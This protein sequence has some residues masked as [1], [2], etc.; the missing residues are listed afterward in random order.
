MLELQQIEIKEKGTALFYR[1]SIDKKYRKFFNTDQSFYVKYSDNIEGVPPSI[2]NIPFLANVMPIAWFV[3]FDVV[4]DE[5]DEVFYQALQNLKEEFLK[6]Y[7]TSFKGELKVKKLVKNTIDGNESALLFSGGLDSF[8]SFIRNKDKNPFLVSIH[9]ADVEIEDEVRWNDFI[10]FNKEEV[11]L[12]EKRHYYIESNLRTFY[13]YHVELLVNIGWWG[14][15]QHGMALIGVLAPLTYKKKVTSILIASSNTEEVDFGW[16]STPGIDEKMKWA[17]SS[18]IHDGYH[19]RRTDK[20]DNVIDYVKNGGEE[21]KLRVCY[22]ELRD[23]YNCSKCAKCQRTMLGIILA[24]D[25][26]NKY[27]F[28]VPD[29][30]YEMILN[31]FRSKK[32]LTKG[33]EYEW[34]C[35]QEKA[36]EVDSFFVLKDENEE[37]NYLKSFID[38]D[39]KQLIDTA[40]DKPQRK[41]IFKFLIRNKFSNLYTLYRNIRYNK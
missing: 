16:G 24:G 26:P 19:L 33:L 36:S 20:I 22:S 13:T 34:R 9:G 4:V 31:N 2:L 37:K 39:L 8:E 14:K 17:N 35:L 25:N 28:E 21:I 23:G 32:T 29:Q 6:Y 3:G 38:L 40:V 12:D 5:L 15:I 30:L 10:R 7:N 41:E 1:Y 27:G 18:V 11:I